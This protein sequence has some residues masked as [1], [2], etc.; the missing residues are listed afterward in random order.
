MDVILS[1]I[2]KV[3]KCKLGLFEHAKSMF[4]GLKKSVY[5]VNI[6]CY[7]IDLFSLFSRDLEIDLKGSSTFL[8]LMLSI[9]IDRLGLFSHLYRC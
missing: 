3:F 1:I 5:I 4:K 7:L 9:H 2:V 8:I 6:I